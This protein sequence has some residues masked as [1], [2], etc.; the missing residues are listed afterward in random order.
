MRTPAHDPFFFVEPAD[1]N[2]NRIALNRADAAHLTKVRRARPGDR[3]RVS[4]GMGRVWQL[5]LT[6]ASATKTEG[7]VV[8]EIFVPKPKPD[9]ALLQGLAKGTKIDFVIQKLVE[10]GIDFIGI[11]ISERSVP[12][13]D[14]DR[15]SK[16]TARWRTVAREAAKQSRRA[17]LPRVEGPLDLEAAVEISSSYELSV[18]ADADSKTPLKELLRDAHPGPVVGTVGPEGGL[19]KREAAAFENAGAIPVNLGTNILRTE[20]AAVVLMAALMYEFNRF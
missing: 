19:T 9:M 11:F 14:D 5:E 17:W 2:G 20:T 1:N 16:A 15:R 7:Q 10:M 18:L 8:E 4:D 6:T 12:D 3:I 13:W